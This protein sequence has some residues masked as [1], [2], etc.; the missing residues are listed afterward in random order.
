MTTKYLNGLIE[1]I[2]S[3]LSTSQQEGGN[4]QSLENPRRH[5]YRT[6]DY[7]KSREYEGVVIAAVEKEREKDT[8]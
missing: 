8:K 3:N 1:L 2:Q 4:Q 5:F 6:L 7:I